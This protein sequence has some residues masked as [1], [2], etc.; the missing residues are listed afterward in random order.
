MIRLVC[1]MISTADEQDIHTAGHDLNACVCWIC[2]NRR[3][4]FDSFPVRITMTTINRNK[5]VMKKGIKSAR[6]G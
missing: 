4:I 1:N 6:Q 3:A 2:V 5:Y